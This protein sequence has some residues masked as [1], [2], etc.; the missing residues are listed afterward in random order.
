MQ[1]EECFVVFS[2]GS[3]RLIILLCTLMNENQKKERV[4]TL[5]KLH[6]PSCSFEDLCHP[7]LVT[8]SSPSNGNPL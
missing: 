1:D 8:T 3:K 5:S 6:S 7:A 2:G 4:S